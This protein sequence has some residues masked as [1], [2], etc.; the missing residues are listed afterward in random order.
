MRVAGAAI[1]DWEDL[2]MGTCAQGD[3]LYIADIGDNRSSR[4]RVT[5][6]RVP[7]PMP[8]SASTK[9]AET[10]HLT[11]QDHPHDAEALLVVPGPVPE[12]FI[13]T[14]DVRPAIYRVQG[15]LTPGQRS[16]LSLVRSLDGKMRITGAAASP[17]GRWVA[18][19]SNRMLLIYESQ[20]FRSGG[21]PVSID[22]TSLD[23]PQGEGVAF[24]RDNDVYLV[25][26]G[27]ND[28]AAGVLTRLHCAFIR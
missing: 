13:I 3:C 6:Y 20:D 27:G 12:L 18:L 8:G 9:P 24:G 23:E 11:Y 10:F 21:T 28:G 15:A 5:I 14:K 17:D 22:L 1:T 26:E 7:E 16:T 4:D 19:R 25:S 2:S